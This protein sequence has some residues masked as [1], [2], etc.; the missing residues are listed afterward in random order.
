MSLR[1]EFQKMFADGNIINIGCGDNPC[2]FGPEC[3]HVDL[4]L[5]DYPNFI[6]A[7]AHNLPFP[8]QSFDTAILGDMLE[9]VSNPSQVL[10]EAGRV[11][12]TVVATIFEEW[13][14]DGLSIQEKIAASEAELRGLGYRDI[15]EQYDD[16]PVFA[17]HCLDIVGDGE[18]PHHYHINNF[19]DDDILAMFRD[20]GL[21]ICVL[22]KFKEGEF[23]GHPFYNWGVVAHRKGL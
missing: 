6:Q 7:D 13:R 14:H 23:E 17:T 19:T 10:R 16:L 5:F 11:A 4:D 20:A 21:E 1:L 3:T 8:D 9:H 2:G 15:R 22:R 12:K 18:I